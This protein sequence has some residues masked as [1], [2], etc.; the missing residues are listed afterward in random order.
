MQSSMRLWN[1]WGQ[2]SHRTSKLSWVLPPEILP[3]LHEEHSGET[4]SCF[5]QQEV[6][7]THCR[8]IP[9][10]FSITHLCSP[11]KQ[12]QDPCPR[13]TKDILL[14]QTP[15]AFLSH[16]KVVRGGETMSLE[17]NLWKLKTRDTDPLLTD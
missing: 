4:L 3:G 5:W 14:S 17:K 10:E 2:Q 7:S 16:L 8:N 1:S 11:G 9:T 13:G 6:K 15:L 12:V